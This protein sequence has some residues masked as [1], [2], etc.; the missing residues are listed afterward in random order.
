MKRKRCNFS[1][2]SR[3]LSVLFVAGFLV[4]LFSTLNAFSTANLFKIKD[5]TLSELSA[6]AEGSIKSFDETKIVSD[7]TFHKLN[8]SA[9]YTIKLQNTD[10]S[11]H[12]VNSIVNDNTNAYISYVHD[13]YANT[14]VK[15]GESF[16]FV[17]IAKY[18]N[19]VTNMG[20]RAQVSDVKFTIEFTDI[21][22]PVEVVVS[23]RTGD[24]IVRSVIILSFCAAGLIVC[25]IVAIRRNKKVAKVVVVVLAA[26]SAITI[27]A[28]VKAAQ[29]SVNSIM[30]ENKIGLFD[31]S[32]VTYKDIND[33]LHE[34]QV[35]YGAP[36]DIAEQTREGYEMNGW[37]N[38]SGEDFDITKPI[39]GDVAI[40]ADYSPISYTIVFDGN[41]NTSGDDVASMSLKY[42]EAAKLNKNSFIMDGLVFDSWNTQ[43]NGEGV[44]YG[45]EQ[46]VKNLS[47]TD[48]ETITLYAQWK[49]NLLTV[50][51]HG[52]GLKYDDGSDMFTMTYLASC[53]DHDVSNVNISRSRNNDY[54]GNNNGGYGNNSATKD[55]IKVEGAK[56][57]HVYLTYG[58]EQGY[59][60]VYVFEG[61]YDGRVGGW[62]DEGQLGT[63]DGGGGYNYGHQ[64]VELDIV[65]DTVTFAFYSDSSVNDYYGYYAVVVGYDENGNEIDASGVY[66]ECEHSYYDGDYAEPIA[67]EYQYFAGWS[68]DSSSVFPVYF[69][70]TDVENFL[71]GRG[72]ETK[73]LYASWAYIHE[74][75][76]DGNGATGGDMD[77]EYY[78]GGVEDWLPYN[79]FY[80]QD[81]FFLGWSTDPNATVP[82]YEDGGTFMP[83]NTIGSTTLYAIWGTPYLVIFDGNGA[84]G[85]YM[86]NQ[87]VIR[88]SSANLDQNQYS[89]TGYQFIGWAASSS[90]T[91]PEYEDCGQFVAPGEGDSTTLYAVW[92]PQHRIALDGNG[93]TGGSMADIY[94][95]PGSS[96]YLTGNTFE[97]TGYAFLGWS[98]D[99][100]ATEAE[101]ADE[102]WF[103]APA[104]GS[105]TTTTLYA[106]WLQQHEIMFD[107]NGATSGSMSNL[108][109]SPGNGARLTR[110]TFELTGYLFLGWSTDPTATEATYRD[111]AWFNAPADGGGTTTTLY[112]V[113]RAPHIVYFDANGG[114]GSADSII[115]PYGQTTKL[116]SVSGFSRT[117][118]QYYGWSTNP[119]ATVAEYQSG[120]NFTPPTDGS[121]STTL[122]VV[123]RKLYTVI[124]DANDG[125]GAVR[126]AYYTPGNSVYVSDNSFTRE[127]YAFIGWG[128]RANLTTPTYQ[129]GSTIRTSQNDWGGELRLYAIWE[130][131]YWVHYD[132]NGES[133]G[134][135]TQKTC[136]ISSSKNSLYAPN[137]EK[138]GYAFIG[139]STDTDAGAR[140]NDASGKPIIY[141]PNEYIA[142]DSRLRSLADEE[143][144]ITVHAAWTPVETDYTFQ[145]FDKTAYEN[146]NPGKKITALR[147][148][149]DGNIYAIAKEADGNWWMISDL[150]LDFSSPS[151]AALSS[152]NTNITSTTSF[153]NQLNNLRGR[154]D[155]RNF[156]KACFTE[157]QGCIDQLSFSNMNNLLDTLPQSPDSPGVNDDQYVSWRSYGTYYSY[158][159]AVA[160]TAGWNSSNA[161]GTNF[162]ATQDICSKGWRLP[163]GGTSADGGEY[164][165][166]DVALGGTGSTTY[167]QN[168]HFVWYEYPRNSVK[169]GGMSVSA[170]SADVSGARTGGRNREVSY[171]TATKAAHRYSA[172]FTASFGDWWLYP[173]NDATRRGGDLNPIRCMAK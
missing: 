164:A 43:A 34:L 10:S 39:T 73:D 44:A 97:L 168:G 137:Y 138:D 95:N 93:A 87:G 151:N 107:G 111:E 58:T 149:R 101:Y 72:G 65:G 163:K 47:S 160:G 157:R 166:L 105:G 64:T 53:V 69:N 2:I 130:Q 154:T 169:S 120:G 156:Q 83:S 8:D 45:D 135:M 3:A 20:D 86:D 76:F 141:G 21:D 148:E 75:I 106:I 122:Y 119:S 25:G 84:T 165:A 42:D 49:L 147:D 57:L 91:A 94:V 145:T 28:G 59:D 114:T 13:S 134:E 104:D 117:G 6:N 37:K 96:I 136:I 140:A 68:E 66:T 14:T 19:A 150:R 5:A 78:Y 171:Y 24:D 54:E 113:W 32:V 63:Y 52:N 17:V 85:G 155:F 121:D 50:N 27:T 62:I 11:D 80:K 109:I 4:S 173:G 152:S 56:S 159:T 162:H 127:G 112:A 103:T 30:F 100:T 161:D 143:R 125:T 82:E 172:M 110:N 48:G 77:S 81:A 15:A 98:T 131:C 158:Y 144:K 129:P 71:P 16:D 29:T 26:V 74:I 23:P 31:K 139:W 67:S 41:G 70:D 7:V 170:G 118:Y 99:P 35:D 124:Y 123:W 18:T 126:Y 167:S 142:A 115:A 60:M 90:A 79:G 132:G 88:G 55:V 38:D 33:E 61:V 46:E 1:A 153:V 51:Y 108:Y 116:A 22:Q 40:R 9:K 128:T 12:I 133:A 92:Y 146:A 102:A 89:R 36:A